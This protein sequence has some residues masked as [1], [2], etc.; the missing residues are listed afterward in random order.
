MYASPDKS[1]LGEIGMERRCLV[2]D[3]DPLV[4]NFISNLLSLKDY[5]V[6][7]AVTREE[8]GE[9]LVR[10]D[11]DLVL[12]DLMLPDDNGFALLQYIGEHFPRQSK[13]TV[14]MTNSERRFVERLPDEGWCAMLI[15]PFA[16][17][18]F[19]RIVDLC[20][21]GAHVAGMR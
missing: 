2:I 7:Q 20:F 4:R 15:K 14:V 9:L 13:H 6:D 10:W 19:Y 8:A 16:I 18:E 1:P 5:R 12:L 17:S 21:E 11:Y 3:H